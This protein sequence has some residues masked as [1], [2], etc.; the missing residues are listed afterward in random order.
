MADNSSVAFQIYKTVEEK[1]KDLIKKNAIKPEEIQELSEESFI[2]E[3]QASVNFY[4]KN[5][6]SNVII[7]EIY[8]ELLKQV[9]RIT[10]ISQITT[11]SGIKLPDEMIREGVKLA[12][13]RTRQI[14]INDN[15]LENDNRNTDLIIEFN[16]IESLEEKI[17]FFENLSEDQ[18]EEILEELYVNLFGEESAKEILDRKEGTQLEKNEF[19]KMLTKEEQDRIKGTRATN[20]PLSDIT[21]KLGVDF[22]EIMEKGLEV[23]MGVV[24]SKLMDSIE[25]SGKVDDISYDMIYDFLIKKCNY[26]PEESK[27]FIIH[28]ERKYKEDPAFL[29]DNKRHKDQKRRSIKYYN[30]DKEEIREYLFQKG[31]ARE[32]DYEEVFEP[33]LVRSYDEKR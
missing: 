8:K 2:N 15:D 13:E 12:T 24:V 4:T 14:E 23:H 21:E 32:E 1:Q 22:N 18:K 31:I 6:R 10:D 27:K 26:S 25:S 7:S 28:F 16:N 3:L 20:N 17:E 30:A 5:I 29:L 19:F 9:D 11:E 33:I